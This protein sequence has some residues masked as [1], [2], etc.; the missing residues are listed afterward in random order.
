MEEGLLPGFSLELPNYEGIRINADTAH[1]DG[2][3]LIRKSL[4]EPLMPVN[5][6]SNQPGGLELIRSSL[7]VFLKKYAQL[8]I[9]SLL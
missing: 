9:S 6:E 5:I 2:W 8:N 3:L 1:G 4:H 7:A